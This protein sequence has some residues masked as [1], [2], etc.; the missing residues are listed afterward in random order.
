MVTRRVVQNEPG[1]VPPTCY[2][3]STTRY[4]SP[5]SKPMTNKIINCDGCGSAGETSVYR[6]ARHAY[7]KAQHSYAEARHTGPQPNTPACR[8]LA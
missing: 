2:L 5:T 7:R 8:A 1:A 6:K 4:T 3:T